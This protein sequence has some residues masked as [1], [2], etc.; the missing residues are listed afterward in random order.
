MDFL[1]YDLVLE[2]TVEE[3]HFVWN[4]YFKGA[5]LLWKYLNKSKKSVPAVAG[6]K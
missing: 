3:N 6:K 1:F 2:R 5:N 4:A